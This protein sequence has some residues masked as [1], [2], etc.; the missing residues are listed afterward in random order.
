MSEKRFKNKKKIQQSKN[1]V[2]ETLMPEFA[3]DHKSILPCICRF[4]YMYMT[5]T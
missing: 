1:V 2:I 3:N 4:Y 5:K